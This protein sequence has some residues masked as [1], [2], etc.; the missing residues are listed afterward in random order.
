MM[1]ESVAYV[2]RTAP[3]GQLKSDAVR[4]HRRTSSASANSV[5]SRRMMVLLESSLDSLYRRH[6]VVMISMML[7]LAFPPWRVML[8]LTRKKSRWGTIF[9]TGLERYKEP[10]VEPKEIG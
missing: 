8:S 9:P 6:C 10:L 7:R 2:L 4:T 3:L 1:A 5:L